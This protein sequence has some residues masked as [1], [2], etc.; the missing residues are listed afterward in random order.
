M[1]GKNVEI[2]LLVKSENVS[3]RENSEKERDFQKSDPASF[4]TVITQKYLDIDDEADLPIEDI[5]RQREQSHERAI[6][7]D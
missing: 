4:L 3:V 7:F 1:I 2:I 6:V 5:Y